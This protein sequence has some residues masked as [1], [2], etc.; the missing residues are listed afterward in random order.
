MTPHCV[1]PY[2][3]VS[4]PQCVHHTRVSVAC[5][6]KALVF[7][8]S[9][10]ASPLVVICDTTPS[11]TSSSELWR[12]PMSRRCWGQTHCPCRHDGKRPDGLTV[13]PW[14]NDRCMIWHFTCPDTLAISHLNRSVLFAGAAANE[15]ERRKMM[16]YCSLSARY[17][18]VQVAVKSL[19]AL[20]EEAY[21]FFCNLGY[22]ITS[23]TTEPRSFQFLIQRLSVAVQRGNAACVLGTVPASIALDELFYI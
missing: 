2:R 9:L 12:Q 20:G 14:A 13:L 3:C 18:F 15:A 7:M 19:G 10:V 17:S 11:T 8:A 22:R 4:G 6:S 21:D 1:L 5:R 23:V 16:K